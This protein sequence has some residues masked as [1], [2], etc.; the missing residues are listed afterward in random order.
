MV[1]PSF[2]QLC[3]LIADGSPT[4]TTDDPVER[5]SRRR[6]HVERGERLAGEFRNLH[7][8]VDHLCRDRPDRRQAPNL[9]P[10]AA[11]S[12]ARPSLGLALRVKEISMLGHLNSAGWA[13][14]RR[15]GDLV[16]FDRK[17]K[18]RLR[19][20][21]R[22]CRVPAVNG[23]LR[24]RLLGRRFPPARASLAD[25]ARRMPQDGAA[26]SRDVAFR[27]RSAL[28]GRVPRGAGRRSPSVWKDE[29][30]SRNR[31]AESNV[32]HVCFGNFSQSD[33]PCRGAGWV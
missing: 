4:P 13:T 29:R 10:A 31:E 2:S 26:P 8:L 22:Q 12:T 21:C 7:R 15:A 33:V 19:F 25:D 17:R 23:R 3:A 6:E 30:K 20:S 24:R 32:N 27:H 16:G 9:A 5:R 1:P 18:S 14:C 11:R 28:F